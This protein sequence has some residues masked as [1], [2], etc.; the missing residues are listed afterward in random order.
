MH[1]FCRFIA[2]QLLSVRIRLVKSFDE[3]M[4]Y[5]SAPLFGIWQSSS[6]NLIYLMVNLIFC[7]RSHGSF[8]DSLDQWHRKRNSSKDS[9]GFRSVRFSL[10]QWLVSISRPSVIYEK[11]SMPFFIITQW[12]FLGY[13]LSTYFNPASL[14]YCLNGVF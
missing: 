9:F 13:I 1:F 11:S 7:Q 3:G 2:I 5:P 6:L 4:T 10:K 8:L 14:C 12:I